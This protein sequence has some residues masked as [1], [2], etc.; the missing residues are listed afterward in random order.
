VVLVTIAHKKNTGGI[1]NIVACL[2]QKKIHAFIYA[3]FAFYGTFIV[4]E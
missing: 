1:V 4:N 2:V 3:L